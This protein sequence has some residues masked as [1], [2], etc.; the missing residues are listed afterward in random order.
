L[1]RPPSTSPTTSDAASIGTSGALGL[2]VVAVGLLAGTVP[3]VDNSFLTHLA[4]GRLIWDGGGF[5]HADPFTFTAAGEPW[6]VQSWLASVVFGAVDEWFGLAGLRVLF[7]VLTAGV[8]AGCWLLTAAAVDPLRRALVVVPVVV[9]A[10]EGWTHRPYLFAFGCLILVL[11]ACEGRLDARWLVPAGWVWMNTHGSWPLGVVAVATLWAGARLD[12]DPAE[13]ERRAAGWFAAGL[14]V[15]VLNPYGPRLLA[16]P[17][18]ALSRREVF[19]N[20]KE[21]Q[22]PTFDTAEHYAFLLL[23]VLAVAAVVRRPSWRAALPLMVFLP[24]ALMSARNLAVAAIVLLPG[25]ARSLAR[26]EPARGS[27]RLPA[28]PLAV[29][30]VALAVVGVARV[31]PSTDFAD[32]AYPVAASD[33]LDAHGLAPTGSR[34]VAR[35]YVG[36]YFEA[37]YGVDASV[38]VDDRYEVIPV[39]VLGDVDTL[40]LGEPG[41]DHVLAS[42]GP[43]AVVWEVTSPLAELLA[44]DAGWRIAYR[45][46][47]WL[48]AVPR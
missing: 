46:A 2:L 33:W 10:A 36:N 39:D 32:G 23:V 14:A 44:L 30:A 16:F 7:G 34:V 24:L 20:I 17:L 29:A 12:G 47:R 18:T 25:T 22:A 31:G 11:L 37:R 42:Y 9:M 43:D 28:L 6:V 5:P 38:F 13:H 45:D 41:W 27:L 40:L 1:P 8:L 35:E 26:A 3:L 15:G 4:T 48:V 19:T 21:W